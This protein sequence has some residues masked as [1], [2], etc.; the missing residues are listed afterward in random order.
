MKVIAR[1]GIPR[2]LFSDVA[3]ELL[4]NSPD[5]TCLAVRLSTYLLT[6]ERLTAECC[7]TTNASGYTPSPQNI[8][9]VKAVVTAVTTVCQEPTSD[10]KVH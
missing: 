3:A 7:N 6:W 1:T 5:D 8:D 2:S 10:E 9:K 4:A